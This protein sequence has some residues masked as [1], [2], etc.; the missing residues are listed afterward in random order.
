MR[1]Q[2]LRCETSR[3]CRMYVVMLIRG[4]TEVVRES[5]MLKTVNLH[6]KKQKAGRQETGVR[7]PAELNKGRRAAPP[8]N[9]YDHDR[10]CHHLPQFNADIEA[11]DP[12]QK[13]FITQGKRKNPNC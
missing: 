13:S 1:I 9:N 11:Q 3:H 5:R 2:L 8:G 10:K 4:E 12:K 6:Q 7:N